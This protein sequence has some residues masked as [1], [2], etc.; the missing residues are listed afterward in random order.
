MNGSWRR[1]SGLVL[2]TV[3]ALVVTATGL[4]ARAAG[5][6]FKLPFDAKWGTLALPTGDYTF[7]V[8][9]LT[10]NGV[11]A[12]YRGSQAVGF[13]H[14]EMLD[15]HE[16]QRKTSALLCIRH[17][18]KITVRALQLPGVGTFYF[19]LSKELNAL[20]A[21]QPQLIETVSVAVSGE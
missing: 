17:D 1:V 15:S 16:N 14:T 12:V 9:H 18:G 21:Q 19:P 13:V 11:I 7:S 3:V 2:S 10:S 20:E 5:G 6:K 4:Q 8:D